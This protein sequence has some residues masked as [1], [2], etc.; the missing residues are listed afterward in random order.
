MTT[1]AVFGTERLGPR[2]ENYQVVEGDVVEHCDVCVI[3]SGAAGAVLANKLAAAG[4]SVVLLEK[5]GY[6]EGE[7]M[8]QR[9]E[10][11]MP[12]LWKNCGMNFTDDL[13]IVIAQGSCL[14]GSTVI[15]DAVC[16]PIPAVTSAQWRSAGVAITDD[17][18]ARAT[19]EVSNEIRVTPVRED[20]LNRNSQMLK[21]GLDL[22]G[23]TKHYAN[24]R[25]CV[26]CMQ[27]GLCHLGC[28][29]ETKQDIRVTYIHRA[30]NDPGS[31]IKVYCNCSAESINYK[32]GM[33]ESV[34]GDFLDRDDNV[35]NRIVVNSR[36]VVLSAGTIA[37]SC[38]LLKNSIAQSKAGVGLALHPAPF[39]LGDFE[40]EVKGNQ[41]I[42]MAYT[43]H[44][45]G[46]TNGVQDGGFLVEGIYVPPLQFS[47]LISAAGVERDELMKRYNN[48][49]MAGV[50][51][52]D[53]SSGTVSLT[54][55]GSAKVAYSP[56]TRTLGDIAKGTELI[57]KMWFKLGATRVVSSHMAKPI[58]SSEA[59]IPELIDAMKNDPKHLLLGS[60]HPQGGNKIGIDP[61]TCVVDS[62]C[63]VYG[64]RNLFVCDAS[65]FPT[66]VGV[67]PQLTVMSLATITAEKII[68][69]WDQDFAPVSIG[70][71]LGEACSIR[72]PMYCGS[73]SLGDMF[74]VRD[75]LLPSEALVNSDKAD[76]VDGENW[77]FDTDTLTI[78]NDRYW[79]G[80]F[81]TDGDLVTRV[82]LYAGGFWKKF[83]KEDGG[84]KGVTH[85]YETPVNAA[86][87]ALDESYPGFGTLIRLR[88]T[89]ALYSGFYDFLKI[90][91]KD[92]ILGKAFGGRGPPRGEQVLTFSMS[93]RYSINFMTQDDFQEI[94]AKK[95]RKP[96]TEEVLGLWEGRFISDSTLSPVMFRFRYYMDQGVLKCRYVFGGVLPGTSK[97][98]FTPQH[99]DMFD[100]TGQLFHD[101][102]G[103]VGKD[104]MVGQY[105]SMKSPLFDLLSRAPGF[106]R[107]EPDRVC[108]PYLLRRV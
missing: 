94:F 28:H 51:V 40:F 1:N 68:H 56:S 33:V 20:E 29:Y 10:D 25:N 46:V 35:V 34:E 89:D 23:Y 5:G 65:V 98:K 50:L 30:L 3:G 12:L 26:N 37:S 27:C 84:V 100:F 4:K 74:E 108:L 31:S 45:F 69:R 70:D 57:A 60:A 17:E 72:Q 8:N 85:P 66:A 88:Y 78:Y 101:E 71:D 96:E 58:V 14:G 54:D 44:E 39:I 86:N 90:V 62:N 19:A 47:L 53:E 49:A 61:A 42:P 73:K 55:D 93:R 81:P 48:F 79:K 9:D 97:V 36:I 99:M 21:R 104:V 80:F 6:F 102:I 83:R 13:R 105:C 77:S 43:L 7:D 18:W 32:D 92:T 38:L 15:N 59:E 24:S 22:M 63:Q 82:E 75:T 11:M 67:N 52:R 103:M 76:I 95:T 64:F 106:L 41:G 91:D 2:K 16:F 107:K 87:E